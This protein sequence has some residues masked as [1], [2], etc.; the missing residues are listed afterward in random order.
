VN[1]L[2]DDQAGDALAR[3]GL[4]VADRP[5]P[6]ANLADEARRARV[7]RRRLRVGTAVAGSA[8]VVVVGAAVL[9]S[10][11]SPRSDGR[12]AVDPPPTPSA[13]SAHTGEQPQDQEDV[14]LGGPGEQLD[15][16]GDDFAA[17]VREVTTDIPFPS[18]QARAVSA[19][20]Q[21]DDMH[22]E[23]DTRVSTGALRGFVA[24]DAICS[25]ADA[26]AAAVTSGDAAGRE[27]AAHALLG[28]SSWPA[29][30][31]LDQRFA[32]QSRFSFLPT[33]QRAA[34]GDD[35]DVMGRALATHVFCNPALMPDLPQAVPSGP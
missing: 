30:T 31:D 4:L 7:R 25:W 32:G 9:G 24:N 14:R 12:V 33:A 35:L 26:W 15:P 6:L 8:L 18:D 34:L 19:Q 16:S 21:Y 10:G 22:D 1:Q 28:A 13:H 20:F 11:A 29:V 23:T 17:V 2:T 27:A 3:L 5:V